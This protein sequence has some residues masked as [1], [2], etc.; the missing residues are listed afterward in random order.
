LA[1]EKNYPHEAPRI[2]VVHGHDEGPIAELRSLLGNLLKK[3]VEIVVLKELAGAGRKIIENLKRLPNTLMSSF[4]SFRQT[5]LDFHIPRKR[6]K[7]APG[8]M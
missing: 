2:F 6:K 8:R 3:P 7:V 1:P 5:T 4:S